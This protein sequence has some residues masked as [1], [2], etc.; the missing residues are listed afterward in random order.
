MTSTN[1]VYVNG[2]RIRSRLLELEMSERDLSRQTGIG[3]SA[4]R[5]LLRTSQTHTSLTVAQLQT[6]AREVGLT[7]AEVLT[8]E[9][10]VDTERDSSDTARR[11]L[12]VLRHEQRIIAWDH[13]VDAFA[14]SSKN[15]RR[16]ASTANQSLQGTGLRVH[17]ANSG[18]TLRAEEQPVSEVITSVDR[19]RARDDS[20]DNGTARVLYEVVAG[21][22]AQAQVPQGVRTPPRLLEEPG[23]GSRRS[24]RSGLH[25]PVRRRQVRLRRLM[26][27]VSPD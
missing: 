24:L 20:M 1:S 18:L 10:P 9:Q 4:I 21:T 12:A 3:Q 27:N 6:L 17:I 23:H 7:V 14:W 2:D 19:L 26:A 25:H 16:A 22:I 13:L 5:G 11:L 8:P 15:L